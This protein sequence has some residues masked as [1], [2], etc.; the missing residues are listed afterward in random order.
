MATTFTLFCLVEGESTSSAFPVKTPSADTVGD[1]KKLIKA[2]NDVDADTLTFW[3]VSF[4]I[5]DHV[6]DEPPISLDTLPEKKKLFPVDEIA[7]VFPD[8]PAKK[9]VH[10]LA[11]RPP[12]VVDLVSELE[13]LQCISDAIVGEQQERSAGLSSTHSTVFLS[14]SPRL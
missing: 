5:S 1:L 11:Q 13:F 3:K 12:P 7:D 6:D 8:S 10:I 4:S 9:T 14:P 2:E